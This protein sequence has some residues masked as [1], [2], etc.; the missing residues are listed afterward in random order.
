MLL[1][2][3]ALVCTGACGNLQGNFRYG[4]WLKV[5]R[6]RG[7]DHGSLGDEVDCIGQENVSIAWHDPY[8]EA[9]GEGGCVAA[10]VGRWHKER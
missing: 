3:F 1:V 4:S 10:R 9:R 6:R 7:R 5:G 2:Y 8:T